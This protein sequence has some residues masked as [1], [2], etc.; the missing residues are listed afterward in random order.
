MPHQQERHLQRLLGKLEFLFKQKG[1]GG[2]GGYGRG[3]RNCAECDD[4]DYEYDNY[5]SDVLSLDSDLSDFD[6]SGYSIGTGNFFGERR[7]LLSTVQNFN[8]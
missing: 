8:P 3:Y 6:F 5:D 1:P 4:Y 7:V 2:R